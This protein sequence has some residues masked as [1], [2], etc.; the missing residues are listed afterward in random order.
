LSSSCRYIYIKYFCFLNYILPRTPRKSPA[1]N[2]SEI[3]GDL[4]SQAPRIPRTP[5]KSPVRNVSE[6]AGESLFSGSQESPELPGNR[7][8]EMFLKL[9]GIFILRLPGSPE[10]PGNR[11]HETFL[12]LRGN[13]YFQAPKLR[14]NT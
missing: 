11:R 2:V 14:G 13:L 4:Y 1:R 5:R 6:I 10:L 9:R 7:R 12:K 3:A 8:Y